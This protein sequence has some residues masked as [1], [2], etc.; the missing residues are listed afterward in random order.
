MPLPN[1]VS[2]PYHG[3][4]DNFEFTQAMGS[5]L[6]NLSGQEFNGEAVPGA[7]TLALTGQAE[8][9]VTRGTFE[10]A[11]DQESPYYTLSPVSHD[12]LDRAARAEQFA[13]LR[14]D[15]REA[16]ERVFTARRRTLANQAAGIPEPSR[17]A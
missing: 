15:H 17:S 14:Q 10:Q 13:N 6:E 1:H 12:P 16:A 3:A 2:N 7:T 11:T 8:F 4:F 5:T 9:Q